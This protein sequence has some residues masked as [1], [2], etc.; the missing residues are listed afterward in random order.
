MNDEIEQ[1]GSPRVWKD[2]DVLRCVH[3][4][5]VIKVPLTV[6]AFGCP[7]CGKENKFEVIT[8]ATSGVRNEQ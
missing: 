4:N 1:V 2:Y 6:M 3:C 8:E 7:H 5:G